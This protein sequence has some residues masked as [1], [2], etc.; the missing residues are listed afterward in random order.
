MSAIILSP[1]NDNIPELVRKAQR[2]VMESKTDIDFVQFRTDATHA[3]T[4]DHLIDTV[5]D[6]VI[7]F[8]DIDCIVLNS[9]IIPTVIEHA[10]NGYLVGNAQSS[11]HIGDG[12]HV[13]V[14]PSFMAISR[15]TWAKMGCPSF[16]PTDRSDVGEE[17][18]W[19]AEQHDI[20]L[21]FL[22]PV[23]FEKSPVPVQLPDGRVSNPICWMTGGLPY[24]LSTT[25][26]LDGQIDTFHSFQSS[27]A[28]TDR[29]VSKCAE[30]LNGIVRF[31]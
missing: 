30:V 19:C 10:R 11:S 25:F 8:M 3:E 16:A 18:T 23:H 21:M 20:P 6:D 26:S 2:L 5:T 13:F 9:N 7:V 15:D 12:S 28:Q 4:L 1:Y 24:G 27:L 17:L 14:A 22:R 31:G 29:F